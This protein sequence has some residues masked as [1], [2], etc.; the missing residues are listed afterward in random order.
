LVDWDTIQIVHV[1]DDEG[2]VELP[3]EEQVYAVLRLE[4]EDDNEKK[5]MEGRGTGCVLQNERDDH[6][7][8]ILVF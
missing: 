3:S 8:A 2:R 6:P 4:K 5:D 7:A 1:L